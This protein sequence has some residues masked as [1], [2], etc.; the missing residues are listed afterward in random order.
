MRKIIL[1]GE[2]GEKGAEAVYSLYQKGKKTEM[3]LDED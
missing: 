3:I 2:S 1:K